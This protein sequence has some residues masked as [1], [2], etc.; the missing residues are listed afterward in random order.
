[1]LLS[2]EP[3]RNCVCLQVSTCLCGWAL[4]ISVLHFFSCWVGNSAVWSHLCFAICNSKKYFRTILIF[5]WPRE[6]FLLL[7]LCPSP[8]VWDK[9]SLLWAVLLW[10]PF[11]I[12]RVVLP[13]PRRRR[14]F[15]RWD[16]WSR[17]SQA[18]FL[19]VRRKRDLRNLSHTDG[20]L[21]L[22]IKAVVSVKC[23]GEVDTLSF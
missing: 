14:I 6:L 17:E 15:T 21:C 12:H 18:E 1:M 10:R 13:G 5:T 2:Q 16:G 11:V 8:C 4:L 9:R 22:E 19:P 3:L 20:V 7:A 23:P